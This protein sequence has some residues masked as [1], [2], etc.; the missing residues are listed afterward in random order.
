MAKLKQRRITL[1]ILFFLSA[2]LI[3]YFE[4]QSLVETK[5]VSF[6]I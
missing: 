6:S 5:K 4:K 3:S 2:L 1:W